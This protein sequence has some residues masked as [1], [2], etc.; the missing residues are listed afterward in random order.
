VEWRKAADAGARSGLAS[1]TRDRL[2]REEIEQLRT[3]AEWAEAALVKTKA[4][5]ELVGKADALLE[6]L[7]ESA[8]T[9]K[10]SIML[11]AQPIQRD[12]LRAL[13]GVVV[14]AEVVLGQCELAPGGFMAIEMDDGMRRGFAE[15]RWADS[16]P[17]ARPRSWDQPGC[18]DAG[19]N[20]TVRRALQRV[21]LVTAWR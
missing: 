4:A 7:S 15:T 19:D 5:L 1:A 3:R 18:R 10:R 13:V 8:P 9:T 17:T 11:V 21:C 12:M 2:D 6:T 14:P 20:V 16:N